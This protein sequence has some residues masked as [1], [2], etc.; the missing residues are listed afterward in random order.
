MNLH[1]EEGKKRGTKLGRS[2]LSGMRQIFNAND[3]SLR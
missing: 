1:L 2:C 3:D